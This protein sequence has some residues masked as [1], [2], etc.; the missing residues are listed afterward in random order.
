MLCAGLADMGDAVLPR[1][2]T[3]VEPM[4]GVMASTRARACSPAWARTTGPVCPV[5][6]DKQQHLTCRRTVRSTAEHVA[7]AGL[8]T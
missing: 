5:T 7:P 3:S 1:A 2:S 6:A 4:I 8:R